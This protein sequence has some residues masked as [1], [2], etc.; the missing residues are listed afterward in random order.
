[1]SAE[2]HAAAPPARDIR[3]RLGVRPVIN[4][5]GT[6]T[7]LGASIVVPEA[8]EAVAAV[9]SEFVE[10][11]DLQC[12][13]SAAIARLCATEA[14]FVTASA[15]AGITVS[16][17]GAMTGA[18]LAAIE[19]LPDAAGLKHEVAIQLGH[20]VGYGAPIEQAV[21][22]A[23]ARVVPVGQATDVRPYQ[24]AGALCPRTAAVL[25]VVAHHT[26]Q[27]G[28]LSLEEVVE[29]AHPQGVPVIVDAA[30]EY[31]LRGFLRRGADVVVY[32]AHK[33]LGG[34]TA[35]IVA[36]QRGLVRAAYLQNHGIGRGMKV[37]K[38]GMAGTIAALE[39]WE[40]R[41]HAAV[42]AREMR[43]LMLWRDRL[44]HWAGVTATIEPDPTGN[45]LDRLQVR[46]DPD[47]AR[48]TA[49]DLADA[50]AAGT[51]P[52]IVRDLEVEHGH[53]QLDPCNLHAGEAEVV[54]GRLDAEFERSR[55]ANAPIAS[56]FAERRR[57]RFDAMLRW[58]D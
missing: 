17:A 37:G 16:V 53:F 12:R 47:A 50:L 10:I 20:M 58:P 25:F 43:A 5:S 13:V 18:D 28:Q 2:R 49:W 33:F 42:R 45:P 22:L 54:A 3:S 23:G 31:D 29:I 51:P 14:G 48:I 15:A 4:V 44:S 56:S 57:R 34:P 46:I 8:I 41:D 39:A 32:S 36:G 9:L 35:G 40:K 30:S 52:V 38:E 19:R 1:M 7:A 11:G 6:M 55:T 21:R 24:L 26:V 27:H